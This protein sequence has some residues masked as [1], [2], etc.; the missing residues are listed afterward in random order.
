MDITGQLH[1]Y[2][3]TSGL[4][5]HHTKIAIDDD[6]V[7]DNAVM[8]G[9][10]QSIV[11]NADYDGDKV[12]LRASMANTSGYTNYE[13]YEAATKAAKQLRLVEDKVADDLAVW[14]KQNNV[15]KD[16]TEQLL[17]DYENRNPN[18][19]AALMSKYNK[20]YV[21][22]FSNMGTRVREAMSKTGFDELSRS[23]GADA[24]F[25][26]AFFEVFEQD[27]ISAKKVFARLSAAHGGGDEGDKVAI[28]ELTSLFN[29]LL[30]GDIDAGITQAQQMNIL[31]ELLDSRQFQS[32]RF[33]LRESDYEAYK[34]LGLDQYETVDENGNLTSVE[35]IPF[36]VLSAALSRFNSHLQGKGFAEGIKAA[37]QYNWQLRDAKVPEANVTGKKVKVTRANT[38]QANVN[39]AKNNRGKG[40]TK[41]SAEQQKGYE[42]AEEKAKEEAKKVV[43]SFATIASD[44]I[45][46]DNSNG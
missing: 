30:S 39:R 46:V 21:G 8:V 5:I 10:G 36:E 15:K 3:S 44:H 18:K 25:I 12:W 34:Q 20:K 33:S 2:P 37:I 13:E 40:N 32:A 35:G 29:K 14:D 4:D 43:D 31:G 1:R 9:R 45:V 17:T 24:K 19:L 42:K 7:S 28:D 26:R 6:N 23:S 16:K 41:K 22:Q 11:T 27:S 38:N